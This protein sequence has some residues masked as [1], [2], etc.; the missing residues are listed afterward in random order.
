MTSAEERRAQRRDAKLWRE[1]ADKPFFCEHCHGSHP[2]AEH[3]ACR[4]AA[5]RQTRTD[6]VDTCALAFAVPE[7]H[8][9]DRDHEDGLL[10]VVQQVRHEGEQREDEQHRVH[11]AA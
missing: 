4:S 7:D 2:L 6:E 3:A 11:L 9:Q 8:A 5:A 10:R 1:L